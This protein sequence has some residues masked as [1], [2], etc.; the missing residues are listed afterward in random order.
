MEFKFKPIG[1]VHSPFKKKEDIDSEKFADSGGF[2]PAQG[3]LEIFQEFEKGLKDIDGFSHLIVLFVFHKS[4]GYRLHTK[5]LLDD[6]LRGV[7]STRSPHRPNPVGMTVVE[8]LERK[9]NRI[10]VF[11]I[12]MIEG[13]P[14]LDIKPYTSRDQKG[15][16]KLGWLKSK[17]KK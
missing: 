5:P 10:K 14:I 12:D 11:G 13:T 4:E 6:T 16:I 3:E 8:M 9:G 15:A 1:V 2:D 17:M 7:F